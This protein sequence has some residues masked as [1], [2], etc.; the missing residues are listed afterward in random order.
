MGQTEIVK[1]LVKLLRAHLTDKRGDI[2]EEKY[3]KDFF[4]LFREA[5]QNGH[6]SESPT[7][8]A[9][10]ISSQILEQLCDTGKPDAHTTNLLNN[11]CMMWDDWEYALKNFNKT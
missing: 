4:D 8:K 10:N 3:R 5:F 6:F 1:E 11:F 2:R 9:D 7:L